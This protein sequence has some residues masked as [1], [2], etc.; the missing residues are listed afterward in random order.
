MTT[1]KSSPV[2]RRNSLHTK[3]STTALS[4]ALA[5]VF[6]SVSLPADAAGLGRLTVNSGLGQPLRAEVEVTSLTDDEASSLKARLAR[7]EAFRQAG[8]EFNP[9][10]TGL[11][12]EVQR[13]GAGAIVRIT[14]SRPVNEP[15]VDLLIELNWNSGKFVREYTFL[16]DPPEL[17]VGQ[18][19][20][21]EGGASQA[22]VVTPSQAPN[23]AIAPAAAQVPNTS[24]PSA[25]ALAAQVRA[26]RAAAAAAA[27]VGAQGAAPAPAAAAPAPAAQPT[28]APV[29][30][31]VP[32][33][34][35]V[36]RGDTLAVIARE[37]QPEARSLN[38]AMVAI[39]RK[40]ESAFFGSVHQLRAGATLDLPSQDEINAVTSAEAVREMQASNQAW[41]EYRARLADAAASEASDTASTVAEGSA[42]IGTIGSASEETGESQTASDELKLSR[43]SSASTSSAATATGEAAASQETDIAREAA[44]RNAQGRVSELERNVADLQRLLELKNKQLADLGNQVAELETANEAA[45]ATTGTVTELAP[46]TEGTQAADS[47]DAAETQAEADVSTAA[48]AADASAE[49]DG[50]AS[51]T[52]LPD[53]DT[54]ADSAADAVTEAA[55]DAVDSAGD[56]AASVAD[57]AS[58]TLAQAGDAVDQTADAAV[59]AATEAATAA[60]Q[61]AA[62]AP[63]PAPTPAPVAPAAQSES[64]VD[65]VMN[66]VTSNPI[67]PIGAAALI[68]IGGFF[69][70]R[71]RKSKKTE[72]RFE[73]TLGGDDAFAANS[74]FGTTGGQDV[75]T[76]NS[77][78]NTGVATDSAVDVHSTE[79]DPIAEAE[80]YIA[81]GREAQ[82]EEIL[83]EA[84]KRQP[85][86]QAI[87]LKL[88]EIY[89]G[90]KD[91]ASYGVVAREMYDATG[92]QNEEWPKVITMGLAVD[93]EN[94]L[95]T[96]E[97]DD[98]AGPVDG[99]PGAAAVAGAAGVAGAVGAAGLADSLA[100]DTQT[101]PSPM[102]DAIN[103][104]FESLVNEAQEAS[105]SI[106]AAEP[107]AI[108]ATDDDDL[109]SLD[110]DL[111]INTEI[112]TKMAVSDDSA[113]L[114]AALE[115]N[116]EMPSLEMDVDTE[117]NVAAPLTETDDLSVEIPS[118]D[119]MRGQVGN[120]A[121]DADLASVG[122]ELSSEADAAPAGD[123][124]KWQEMATKLDLASAYEEIGD[125]EGAR[126]LLDEVL[127]DGDNA[128]QQKARA[129][130]SKIS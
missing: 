13:Q 90:R 110:F 121:V 120:E 66:A 92:G 6:S 70:W 68:A 17:R 124:A 78:F 39:Y 28:P 63:T 128:Q 100:Q 60:G 126:E 19:Q 123:G 65:T 55:A 89:A 101:N 95:Y 113:D 74:L 54:A 49:T 18:P 125:K 3:F 4:L 94:P 32:S 67:V 117:G 73:D 20:P 76:S 30:P 23:S 96:G 27:T 29:A 112:D 80:V 9:A 77:L 106:S 7:P 50:S 57:S 42:A 41:R 43:D 24:E 108:E 37:L 34:R 14:S 72:E 84:L 129:M 75:D 11:R 1:S 102:T 105:E 81:Y 47:V 53:V 8:L 93:P 5:T 118:L 98:S 45:A 99:A 56:T 10:L 52:A 111:D 130:L 114:N 25:A 38:Q 22:S 104:S 16:L 62:P 103:T 40:N 83:K 12:F 109:N 87:R 127:K 15:F 79:V 36:Q 82:A 119:T 64:M 86:R 61:A 59:T 58:E 35:V 97:I 69:A 33:S 46:A 88:L 26:E 71:R 48:D 31:N 122:L 91:G 2:S 115:A 21:I 51:M 44:L 85:D 107:D 116:V